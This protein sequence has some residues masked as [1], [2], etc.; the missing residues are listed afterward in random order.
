MHAV[1]A[2]ESLTRR[3]IQ[4]LSQ[5]IMEP[6]PASTHTDRIS[7][8]VMLGNNYVLFPSDLCACVQVKKTVLQMKP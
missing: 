5:Q 1:L 8:S 7:N 6:F 3:P 4:T 2:E